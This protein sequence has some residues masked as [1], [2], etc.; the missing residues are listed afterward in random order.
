M[1]K[2]KS[3]KRSQCLNRKNLESRLARKPKSSS[4]PNVVLPRLWVSRSRFSGR[5][6]SASTTLSSGSNSTGVNAFGRLEQSLDGF[7]LAH[8]FNGVVLGMIFDQPEQIKKV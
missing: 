8:I 6:I 3:L 4:R 2:T 7:I 1:R 5:R